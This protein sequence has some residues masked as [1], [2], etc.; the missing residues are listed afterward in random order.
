V[1]LI[2]LFCRRG[3]EKDSIHTICVIIFICSTDGRD[4][5]RIKTLQLI[6]SLLEI[7]LWRGLYYDNAVK[8]FRMRQK[9]SIL[10]CI[11]TL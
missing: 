5:P 3:R 6:I 11:K 1:H 7:S 10:V 9:Y 2:T 4:V 8:R